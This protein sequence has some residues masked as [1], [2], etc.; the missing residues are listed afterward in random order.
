M[1]IRGENARQCSG[2]CLAQSVEHAAF[3][4]KVVGLNPML[5]V[6]ITSKNKNLKKKRKKGTAIQN[7]IWPPE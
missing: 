5:G 6:E 2:A 1:I 3:D 7:N 4:L